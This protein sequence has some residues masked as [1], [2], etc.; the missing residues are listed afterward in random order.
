MWWK[1]LSI[2]NKRKAKQ[3]KGIQNGGWGKESQSY[4]R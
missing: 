4:T 3:F 2:A 1:R